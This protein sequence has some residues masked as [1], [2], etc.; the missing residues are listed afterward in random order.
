MFAPLGVGRQALIGLPTTMVGGRFVYN[1]SIIIVQLII[2]PR[3]SDSLYPVAG[4]HVGG[5]CQE[6]SLNIQA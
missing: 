6:V 4:R 3:T 2:L 1:R 5:G